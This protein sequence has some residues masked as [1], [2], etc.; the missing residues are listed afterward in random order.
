MYTLY[1]TICTTQ[2]G[3]PGAFHFVPHSL[4]HALCTIHFVPRSLYHIVCT[5]Q[6]VPR[7]LGDRGVLNLEK[8]LENRSLPI[9]INTNHF[10]HASE[11]ELIVAP[12]RF[13]NKPNVLPGKLFHI[14]L[15]M[16]L[17]MI[18]MTCCLSKKR[19]SPEERHFLKHRSN[20]HVVPTIAPSC[21]TGNK[22]SCVFVCGMCQY[23]V[24]I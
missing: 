21:N 13:L 10:L 24:A 15:M 11:L 19:A 14:I 22:K 6:F 17:V 1:H 4:Y 7:S 16:K 3:R 9:Q 20:V 18:G 5:T 23:D 8:E 12:T 2:F